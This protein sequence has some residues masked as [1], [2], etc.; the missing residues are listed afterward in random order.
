MKVVANLSRKKKNRDKGLNLTCADFY[1]LKAKYT[2]NGKVSSES[3][4]ANIKVHR[5]CNFIF[6][7][8]SY[9]VNNAHV[10][11]QTKKVG[12]T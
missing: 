4:S 3:H 7:L 1:S 8:F 9:R 10:K 11:Q 12:S 6:S 5:L 2:Q